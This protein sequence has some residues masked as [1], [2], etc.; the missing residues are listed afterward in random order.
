MLLTRGRAPRRGSSHDSYGGPSHD[1]MRTSQKYMREMMCCA[2]PSARALMLFA[3]SFGSITPSVALLP[4]TGQAF[5]APR[6]GAGLVL[7]GAF[8]DDY[9]F[10]SDS[11]PGLEVP[12][13]GD[14]RTPEERG[15]V[16]RDDP[17]LHHA[18]GGPRHVLG[19]DRD[20]LPAREC[21]A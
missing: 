3:L 1:L 14:A 11:L 6:A 9:L 10:A 5:V 17:P 19:D 8:V 12:E 7:V 15:R 2:G 20:E 16:L 21:S 13:D 4:L 18:D